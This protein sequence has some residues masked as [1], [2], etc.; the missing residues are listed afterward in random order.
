MKK[1]IFPSLLLA[2][3]LS[4]CSS[5]SDEPRIDPGIEPAYPTTS[6]ISLSRAEQFA[7]DAINSF[8]FSFF[9]K[10]AN[11]NEIAA[12]NPSFAVSP[13]SLALGLSIYA[14]TTGDDDAATIQRAFSCEDLSCLNSLSKKLM[15][16]L[17]DKS[18]K[19]ELALANSVWHRPDYTPCGD[20]R[21]RM[22]FGFFA[23][24]SALDFSSENAG[25]VIN[26]W[27]SRNTKGLINHIVDNGPI[28]LCELVFANALYFKSN[29]GI[30][31]DKSLT[32]DCD[33]NAATGK[34]NV[35]MMHV[36]TPLE[37]Y[38]GAGFE[39]VKVP[40]E[41]TYEMVVM[42]PDE[43]TVLTDFINSVSYDDISRAINSTCN[44]TVA[45][46]MPRFE[47][48]LDDM[49]CNNI[50]AALGVS[51][52]HPALD[53]FFGYSHSSQG[54]VIKHFSKVMVDEVGTEAAAVTAGIM[55]G[56][57]GEGGEPSSVDFTLDRPFI[58][59]IRNTKTGSIIM[60]G[61]YTQPQ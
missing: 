56:F 59:L 42:L 49:K 57:I 11:D 29:W 10:V 5:D 43:N 26:D 50:L 55:F 36:T 41:G 21:E 23:E 61:Q 47:S 27:C 16:F 20:Y 51:L 30:K 52:A 19:C 12:K 4:A 35:K 9:A 34:K 53:G 46:S 44:T 32:D 18:N 25:A 45:L 48:S 54:V 13:V 2:A 15:Q 38:K 8:G 3:A 6:D 7:N 22:N 40:Y 1:V 17:P 37:Y 31:F 28:S 60:M 39:A 58:Y 33:F 14:N 24:I